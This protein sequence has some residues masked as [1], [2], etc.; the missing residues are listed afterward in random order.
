MD[1][2]GHVHRLHP[3]AEGTHGHAAAQHERVVVVGVASAAA[4]EALH[5]ERGLELDGGVLHLARSRAALDAARG[6]VEGHVQPRF[7]RGSLDGLEGEEIVRGRMRLLVPVLRRTDD[8]RRRPARA[9]L[10]LRDL[11]LEGLEREGIGGSVRV[12]R[13]HRHLER[14]GL[15][16]D[17]QMRVHG[18]VRDG[19]VEAEQQHHGTVV[20]PLT[21]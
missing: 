15:E 6:R 20:A 14:M 12:A 3:S 2:V 9:R 11:G 1:G 10:G 18:G 16:R 7:G 19:L 8:H 21:A 4:A 5:E 17:G 13:G